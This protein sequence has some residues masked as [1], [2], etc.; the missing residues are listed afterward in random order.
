MKQIGKG[1]RRSLYKVQVGEGG[2][3][4]NV[5]ILCV[6]FFLA[7]P[8]MF[9][10]HESSMDG[11]EIISRGNWTRFKEKL[12]TGIDCHGKAQILFLLL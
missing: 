7:M 12:P 6:L 10:N 5:Y 11:I 4:N 2:R 8:T 1:V 9:Q 3:I